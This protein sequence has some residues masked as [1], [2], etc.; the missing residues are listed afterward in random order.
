MK[1]KIGDKVRVLDGSNIKD[2]MGGWTIGMQYSIGK[3]YTIESFE[4]I[5]DGRIGY[6]ME[7]SVCI[8]DE[9]GLE[10]AYADGGFCTGFKGGKIPTPEK[11]ILIEEQL[12]HTFK[13]S[14]NNAFDAWRKQGVSIYDL[15]PVECHKPMEIKLDISD[16][17]YEEINRRLDDY[18]KGLKRGVGMRAEITNCDEKAIFKEDKP[19]R[20]IFSTNEGYRIDKSNNTKIPTITTTVRNAF[21]DKAIVTCDK[22]NYDE[23][24]GVLEAIAQI[25]CKGSFDKQYKA[26]VKMNKRADEVKRTCIYCGKTFDTVEEKEAHEAWHI[27]RRKARH[28]RYKLRKRAKEIAFEEQAKKMALEMTTKEDKR[29]D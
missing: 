11:P 7:G 24:Q 15:N 20:F 2:Y 28:E 1:Y 6:Y 8:F 23:R 19:M 13:D 22:D 3:V 27:E 9:R 12:G 4:C 25:Y 16:L 10:P 14:L 18:F 5:A 17:D 26:A 21:G 29:D